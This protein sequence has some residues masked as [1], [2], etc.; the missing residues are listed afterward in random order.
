MYMPFN[1]NVQSC[2]LM[3][4]SKQQS[5]RDWYILFVDVEVGA[6]AMSHGSADL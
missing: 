2:N 5:N 1:V 4:E 3:G 6:P